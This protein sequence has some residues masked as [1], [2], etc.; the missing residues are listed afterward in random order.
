MMNGN[1]VRLAS[2]SSSG[3]SKGMQMQ[4]LIRTNYECDWTK[5]GDGTWLSNRETQALRLMG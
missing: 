2:S 1:C 4:I 5:R 3:K